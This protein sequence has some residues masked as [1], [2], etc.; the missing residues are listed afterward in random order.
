[1]AIGERRRVRL[2]AS[3]AGTRTF[4]GTPSRI[5]RCLPAEPQ[6]YGPVASDPTVSRAIDALAADPRSALRAINIARAA[7]R[8]N[9]WTMAGLDAPDHQISAAS[10]LIIDVDATLVTSHS[11]KEEAAPT[12]D[13]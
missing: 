3:P 1:M 5:S 6:L 2:V 13:R 12:F 11:D 10:P 4:A 7:A 8:K 9:A